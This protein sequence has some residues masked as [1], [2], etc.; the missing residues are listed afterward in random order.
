MQTVH[1]QET[2]LHPDVDLNTAYSRYRAYVLHE[3][4]NIAIVLALIFIPLFGFWD[5]VLAPDLAARFW[6][7]RLIAAGFALLYFFFNNT[8]WGKRWV[9]LTAWLC[10][11]TLIV[12]MIPMIL[13]TGA[14]RSWYY[15]AI[16][17]SVLA[18][19][20]VLPINFREAVAS[21]IWA[22][23]IYLM[24]I[25]VNLWVHPHVLDWVALFNSSFFIWTTF[26]VLCAAAAFNSRSR[27]H[28][29]RLRRETDRHRSELKHYA[30][31]LEQIVEAKIEEKIKLEYQLFQMQK[32]E[33][34]GTM[35][36]G[37]SHDFNNF[38]W[39]II[40][41]SSYI[42]TIRPQDHELNE[43]LGVIENSA[44]NAA[45]LI[46]SLLSFSRKDALPFTTT[47]DLRDVAREIS[48]LLQRSV[49]SNTVIHTVFSESLKP[50]E[51]NPQQLGQALMN[52]V[53]NADHALPDGG[54]VRIT[55][56]DVELTIATPGV[57]PG[58]YVLLEVADNGTGIPP[59]IQAKIFEPF[60]TTKPK[61]VGTGFG[62]AMVQRTVKG[63]RGWI[64][65]DSTLGEGS[66]FRLYFP[67]TK[68]RPVV[69]S[70][71][72]E[73]PL[74]QGEGTILIIDDESDLRHMLSRILQ[75]L[76]YLVLES[77]NG[78]DGLR[79]YEQHQSSLVLVILDLLMPV[80]DGRETFHRIRAINP[81]AKV[82]I[83]SGVMEGEMI[84]DVL[85]SG[86]AG[87]IVKPYGVE[88]ISEQLH[89]LMQ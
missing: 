37:I 4:I 19:I 36:S 77:S 25:L 11:T 13:S 47:L 58:E 85:S 62:L 74:F 72:P 33:A 57:P 3:R 61:G 41:Y 76:G 17:L 70:R 16:N 67:V 79:L 38:L 1:S 69:V 63:H 50:I 28:S 30:T 52:L 82:L 23:A 75:S 31:N 40:G 24:A 35:A 48:L 83:S 5:G 84:Q 66:I 27:L 59:E 42:R 53:I 60:F 26:L 21:C 78:E 15:A 54:D 8:H 14:E 43:Y 86:A 10:L 20:T 80:M 45:H 55:V 6:N 64:E 89:K 81:T 68:S 73:T 34:I 88:T 56:H 22:Y 71:Q 12:R 87:V 49:K 51:G 9:F 39:G 18:F 2:H 29:F 7:Y 44:E 32:M 46:R 65:L